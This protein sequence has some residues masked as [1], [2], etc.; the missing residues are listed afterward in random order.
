MKYKIGVILDCAKKHGLSERD[1]KTAISFA[2][3]VR[4]RNFDPPA[5]I[6]FAG[7]NVGGNL[8][9]ILAAEQGDGSLIVYHAMELTRKMAAELGLI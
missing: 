4:Y 7:P 9:E 8:I 1:I 6:A 2:C 5:H 3:A